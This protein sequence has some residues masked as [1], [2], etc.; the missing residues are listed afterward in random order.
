MA[1]RTH[2]YPVRNAST[3]RPRRS[4]AW[5]LGLVAAA[6]LSLVGG[7][8]LAVSFEGWARLL[9]AALGFS[10]YLFY[11]SRAFRDLLPRIFIEN[12]PDPA[13]KP[14]DVVEATAEWRERREHHSAAAA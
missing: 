4:N 14:R 2:R 3:G 11:F 12:D 6:L 9:F 1:S 13:R 10:G 8:L 7:A 5:I